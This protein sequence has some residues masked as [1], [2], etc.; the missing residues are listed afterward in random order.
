MCIQDLNCE[1]HVDRRISRSV[2][3]HG[4]DFDCIPFFEVQSRLPAALPARDELRAACELVILDDVMISIRP[5]RVFEGLRTNVKRQTRTGY[6]RFRLLSDEMG[7]QSP[8]TWLGI[9]QV[10]IP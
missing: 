5:S 8:A 6:C 4:F 2:R 3:L 7:P 1:C 9:G 10:S